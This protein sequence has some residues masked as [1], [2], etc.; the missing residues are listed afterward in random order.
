M[1]FTSPRGTQDILPSDS[2]RFSAIEDIFRQTVKLYGYKEIRTPIFESTELF[3]RGV[4]GDTDIVSKQMYSFTTRGGDDITLRPEGTAGAVRAVIQNNLAVNNALCKI[5]YMG[6]IFRYERPQKGRYRQFTQLGIEV[7]GSDSSLIDAETLALAD[8]FLRALG[9]TDASLELNSIGCDVCRPNYR[10]L[11][12]EFLAD[13]RSELCA[14]CNLRYDTN[15]LRI[16]DCKI[17]R[18]KE[19]SSNAPVMLDTLCDDCKTHFDEVKVQLD[20]LGVAYKVN[21]YIVR[22]LDYYTKTAFEFIASSGLGSQ[23]TVLAGGR[24]DKLVHELGGEMTPAIGFAAGLERLSL[25]SGDALAVAEEVPVFVAAL[26]KEAVIAANILTDKLRKNGIYAVCGYT[27]RGLKG[28]MKEANKLNSS[29]VIILGEDEL[30]NNSCVLKNMVDST[31]ETV[32]LND[33]IEIINDKDK[34]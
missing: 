20:N 16:L 17:E 12:Q 9:I 26:G 23:S 15:P 2:E 33:I 5:Y 4:G 25:S 14:D 13:K 31:Q 19:L 8:N 22:G 3:A 10:T 27:E 24:Y 30:K 11:L 7:F 6:P 21:P 18:C 32:S 28:Q 29:L 1:R 34:N